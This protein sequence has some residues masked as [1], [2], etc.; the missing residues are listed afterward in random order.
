[1]PFLIGTLTDRMGNII[2]NTTVA[3]REANNPTGDVGQ[4]TSDA[5][6]NYIITV[7]ESG[8]LYDLWVESI[9]TVESSNYIG[10]RVSSGDI[11]GSLSLCSDAN[12]ELEHYGTTGVCGKHK[13]ST[14]DSILLNTN[15]FIKSFDTGFQI[16][17]NTDTNVLTILAVGN[18]AFFQPSGTFAHIGLHG[19]SGSSSFFFGTAKARWINNEGT[20]N[21]LG[22]SFNGNV[23]FAEEVAFSKKAAFSPSTAPDYY[24]QL[25]SYAV[26][27]TDLHLVPRKYLIDYVTAALPPA[28]NEII[29]NDTF[30]RVTDTGTN[31]AALMKLDNV[32]VFKA[33]AAGFSFGGDF[34]AQDLVHLRKSGVTTRLR[35]ERTGTGASATVLSES[36]VG[37]ITANNFYFLSA[38]SI[39][40]T[41]DTSQRWGIGIGGTLVERLNIGGSINLNDYLNYVNKGTPANPPLEQCRIFLRASVAKPAN[42]ELVMLIKKGGVITEVVI[43]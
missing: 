29:Q 35:V 10:R 12:W 42:N 27:T 9:N 43:G 37:T 33:I 39:A 8:T 1:M 40:G 3:A 23:S 18:T 34:N 24:P 20:F 4:A 13:A 32:S 25:S 28:P 26:P 15:G 2:P 11:V 5:F 30:F 6:G 19:A 31:G 21:L 7:A 17:V 38:G 14:H 16:R 36:S 41:I 22:G